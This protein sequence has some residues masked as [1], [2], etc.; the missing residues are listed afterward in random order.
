MTYLHENRVIWVTGAASG[1]GKAVA[2]EIVSEGGLVVG[3]DLPTADFSWADDLENVKC[4]TGSVSDEDHNALA[5]E[6]AINEFGHLD[7]AVLNAGMAGRIDLFEGDMGFFDEVM[8]VNVRAVILGVRECASVMRP[9]SAITVTA[10]TS[11]MR[12]DP[13]MWVYNTSKAAVI[14]LVRSTSID[15]AAKGIRINA[16]CPGPTETGMTTRFDGEPYDNMRRR[17]PL[18]RWGNALEIATAH[19]F[20]LSSKASFITGAHLPVDGGMSANSGQFTPPPFSL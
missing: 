13:G 12:G 10:S 17:I 6:T 4:L 11:G 15:L 3:S 7:G 18:Q 16:V 20:L 8:D 14:N 2:E 9:G 5:V 19:S 1:I